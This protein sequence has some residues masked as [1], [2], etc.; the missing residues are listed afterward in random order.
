M[1]IR[2]VDLPEK[3]TVSEWQNCFVFVFLNHPFFRHQYTLHKNQDDC[4]RFFTKPSK[5]AK[6][7]RNYIIIFSFY[8]HMIIF[9]S[10][11][12][13]QYQQDKTKQQI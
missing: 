13:P 10:L 2:L 11:R 12:S 7:D 3:C 5:L 9:L 1:V 6:L 8:R 4:E